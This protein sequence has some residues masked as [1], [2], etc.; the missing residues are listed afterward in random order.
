VDLKDF[1]PGPTLS[2][3]NYVVVRYRVQKIILFPN[4]LLSPSTFQKATFSKLVTV[5]CS[6]VELL[7]PL[8]R[9][10]FFS[11]LFRLQNPTPHIVLSTLHIHFR[12]NLRRD[13]MT[14]CR[15]L[16]C[17]SSSLLLLSPLLPIYN[18][19]YNIIMLW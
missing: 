6:Y 13:S 15:P 1:R 16:C 9:T 14:L 3:L 19:F 8:T 17:V 7:L 4:L 18:R 12:S 11:R 10:P 5:L 2:Y